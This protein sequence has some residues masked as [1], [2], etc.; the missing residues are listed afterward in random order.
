MHALLLAVLLAGGRQTDA[1]ERKLIAHGWDLLAVHPTD[2][3]A[4]LDLWTNLPVD[5]VSLHVRGPKQNDAEPRGCSIFTDPPWQRSWFSNDVI[6]LRACANGGLRHNFLTAYWSPARRIAWTDD[7]AWARIASNH[8]VL[9][10]LAREGRAA[11][12]LVDPEDYYEVHQYRRLATD[13]PWPIC[14]ALARQRGAELMAAI[15][16]EYPQITLL[17]FWLFSMC[18]DHLDDPDPASAVEEAGDLWPSFLNGLLRALPPGARLVDG[19]EHAYRYDA[20][21]HDFHI[22]AW[23]VHGPARMLVG[24]D[25]Q[26]VYAARVLAGF[27][28]YLD[29]YIN[30]PGSPWYF[31]ELHGSRARRLLANLAAA[32]AAADE[33]VWVYGEQCD[34]VRWRLPGRETNRTWSA[35]I[36]GFED[37]LA[38]ARN[39]SRW[40]RVWVER[41]RTA[42]SITNLLADG[43]CS[44]TTNVTAAQAEDPL[45]A[46]WSRWR[47]EQRRAGR[48]GVDAN[49]GRKCAGS[50]HAAGV[51]EGCFVT[52]V[53]L[54]PQTP[55]VIEAHARGGPA[56]VLIGWKQ[57]GAWNWSLPMPRLRFAEPLPDGWRRACDL[58]TT[59][60]AADELVLMLSVRQ[61]EGDAVWFDDISVVPLPPW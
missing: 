26:P 52:S 9:A 6:A 55:V 38:I 2:V 7:D 28:I 24:P 10:W 13:P 14:A 61:A 19:D 36:A 47:R 49:V 54:P 27:G 45:P 18:R 32:T 25:V 40:A 22:G 21:R 37:I 8:A 48:L 60:E 5:G 15:A 56:T 44:P 17:S 41:Q 42:G 59:P 16:A 53:R 46:G 11:G 31:G 3:A 39:P 58:V 57:S 1:V 23:R 4:H 50:L 30:P 35:S 29:M 33:F 43:S 34:W 51:E 12:I 20:S